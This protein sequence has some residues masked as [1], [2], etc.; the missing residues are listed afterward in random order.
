MQ[1]IATCDGRYLTIQTGNGDY[2]I[3]LSRLKKPEQVLDWIH[4]VIVCKTW[5]REKAVDILDAIFE[6]IPTDMWSGKA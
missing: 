5:G 2:D 1:K 6:V 3:E 4:Q